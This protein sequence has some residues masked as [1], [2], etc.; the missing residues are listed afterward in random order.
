MSKLLHTLLHAL[1]TFKAQVQ[2]AHW[3]VESENFSELHAFF[4]NLYELANTDV[5]AVAEKIR[6][7]GVPV[8][9]DPAK[10]EGIIIPESVSC[11]RELLQLTLTNIS[12]VLAILNRCMKEAN[13]TTNFGLQ[14]YF[15]GL[16]EAYEKQQWMIKSQLKVKKT[17]RNVLEELNPLLPG[18]YIDSEGK[19]HES[20]E[21]KFVVVEDFPTIASFL[22]GN[23]IAT[24]VVQKVMDLVYLGK[25]AEAEAYLEKHHQPIKDQVMTLVRLQPQVAS[26]FKTI[27]EKE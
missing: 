4:G 3:N 10:T 7:L 22:E 15:G 11:P 12:I 21:N 24:E 23:P 14:N 6:V 19:E 8:E 18:N 9:F 2:I 5:D 20:D 26:R 25:T 17:L 16:I 1:N 13:D 27:N